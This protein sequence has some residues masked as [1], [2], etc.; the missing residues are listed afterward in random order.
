MGIPTKPTAEQKKAAD[1]VR[2]N[3]WVP[4]PPEKKK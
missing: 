2:K 1:N 3:I 4:P